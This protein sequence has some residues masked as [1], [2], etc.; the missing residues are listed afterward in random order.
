MLDLF[1]N[2]LG[3]IY[4]LLA[5]VVAITIHEFAHAWSADRLGDPTPGLQGRLTLNPLSHLDPI[6]TIMLV[7]VHFGWGKPVQFDQFNLRHPRRD[8]AIIS[9]AG[10]AANIALAVICAI[11]LQLLFIFRFST[12]T[13][14][15]MSLFVYLLAG[16]LK[17]LISLNVVL[18]V[19]NL[20]P[21]HPLDGFKIVG[22]ILPEE[23]AREWYQ[24]ER[25][26]ILFLLF[27]LFPIF[28]GTAPISQIISPVIRLILSILLPPTAII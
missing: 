4:W 22:G 16:F 9:I 15:L 1:N 27:L 25:Y 2:P 12:I 10:P 11:V 26:G 23:K 28:G 24:L 7:L 3:F 8:S 18:A 5:L 21:I 13:Y 19:F 17:T 14:S 20:I 6:G